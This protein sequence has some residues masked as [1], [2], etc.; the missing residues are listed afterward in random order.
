MNRLG[1]CSDN[2]DIAISSHRH[3]FRL[4]NSFYDAVLVDNVTAWS[5]VIM[6]H[7]RLFHGA[8]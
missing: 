2:A 5:N 1:I 8:L 7:R 4:Q 6:H 3:I